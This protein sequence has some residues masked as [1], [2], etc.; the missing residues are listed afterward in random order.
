[1]VVIQDLTR[2][3]DAVRAVILKAQSGTSGQRSV[4]SGSSSSQLPDT[5]GGRPKN[6]RRAFV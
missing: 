4:A 2:V 6:W 3:A 1:M 5:G